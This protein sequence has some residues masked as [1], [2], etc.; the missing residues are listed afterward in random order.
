MTGCRPLW[1]CVED[2]SSDTH[3]K[4]YTVSVFALTYAVPLA[5]LTY[6]YANVVKRVWLRASPGNADRDR[7]LAQLRSKRKVI[8]FTLSAPVLLYDQNTK[9]DSTI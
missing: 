8:H 7:D 4:L 1:E 3:S 9:T 5:A 2:W 6:T